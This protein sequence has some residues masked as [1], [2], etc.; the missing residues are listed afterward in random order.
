MTD[1]EALAEA[2][3]MYVDWDEGLGD[4]RYC[5]AFL[6][7]HEPDCIVLVA[8]KYAPSASESHP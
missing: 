7:L 8:R 1:I 4:C 5:Q 2:V 6:P 3:L